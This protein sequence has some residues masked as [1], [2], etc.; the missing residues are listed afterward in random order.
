MDGGTLEDVTIPC[1]NCGA[2][3]PVVLFE[4][5]RA[6]PARIVRCGSCGLI[7]ASPRHRIPDHALHEEANATHALKGVL[8]D[9][10]HPYAWRLEKESGQVRDFERSRRILHRLYPQGGKMVEVG[11]GL[12]YLLKSFKDEGWDVL[13]VDPWRATPTFTQEA[14]GIETVP[15]TLE[16]AKLP[17]ASTDVVVLL[18][19]IEHV[20]D[21]H[22]TLSEIYRVLKPGGHLVMETPRYDTLMFKLLGHRERSLRCDGHIYFFTFESLQKAYE[23]AGFVE[24]DTRAVGR[25]LSMDRLLWN[26]GTVLGSE[27]LREALRNMG[28]KTGIG[29]LKFSL[30]LRDMQRVIVRKELM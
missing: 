24:V 11:S 29:T 10:D 28:R 13:G 26:V 18:H 25:T 5:G 15:A 3:A 14:H 23:K 9:S 6:Q 12:G 8:N 20:P 27:G 1:N 22:A 21:P 30:N 2:D 17:D 4:A 16:E 19:V 7:Y